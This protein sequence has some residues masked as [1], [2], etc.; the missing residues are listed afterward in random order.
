MKTRRLRREAVPRRL[1]HEDV[2]RRIRK[3]GTRKLP[4]PNEGTKW[5]RG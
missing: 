2:P 4:K 5:P 3:R 1:R